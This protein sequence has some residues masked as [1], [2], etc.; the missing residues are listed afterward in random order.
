MTDDAAA[1][2][3]GGPRRGTSPPGRARRPLAVLAAIVAGTAL[4]LGGCGGMERNPGVEQTPPRLT[5]LFHVDSLARPESVAWDSVRG[6]WLVTNVGD[7]EEGTGTGFV[8]SVPA[9]GG[10]VVRRA[11]DASTPGLRLDGPKGI[12]VRGDRAYVADLRRVVAL[13]LAGDSAAWSREVAGSRS[14][15]D[16][17]LGLDGGIY[18]SDTR[19]DAVWHLPADGSPARRLG[20]AGSLR[21]PDGVLAEG[22]AG[23]AP[24]RLLVAGWEG[25]VLALSADSSVTL[26]AGSPDFGRL[27]GLQPAPDGGLLVTDRSAGRLQHLRRRDEGVW[28]AGVAW[29][30]GLAGPADFLVRDSVLAL[31]ELEADRVTF[32][33]IG[34]S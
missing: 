7:G 6:R 14:L 33:R 28:Q 2:P 11:Y 15:N 19:G 29:L 31:P 17:A 9:E 21:S 8:T 32:Y 34:G 1:R 25:A 4:P 16:V 23:G 3:P 18:V 20:A 26:L 27:D 30:D 24:V 10:E 5:A 12:A 22:A 13:D